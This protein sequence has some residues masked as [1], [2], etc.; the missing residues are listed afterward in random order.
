MQKSFRCWKDP[1][2][3]GQVNLLNVFKQRGLLKNS[4]FC[5]VSPVFQ[6]REMHLLNF[7]VSHSFNGYFIRVSKI[8]IY[9]CAIVAFIILQ[10]EIANFYWFTYL[11]RTFTEN[12]PRAI[13]RWKPSDLSVSKALGCNESLKV[14]V[15]NHKKQSKP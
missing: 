14:F 8:I 2:R 10:H 6:E 11:I 1:S 4:M 15:L 7:E 5:R 3:S 9:I 12:A 13:D